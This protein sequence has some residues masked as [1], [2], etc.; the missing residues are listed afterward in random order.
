M[1]RLIESGVLWAVVLMAG[2]S[3]TP[4]PFQT[5]H[6]ILFAPD[7]MISVQQLAQRLG[8]D[9]GENTISMVT[10]RNAEN[11][12]MVFPD[13]GGQVSVNGKSVK[14]QGGFVQVRGV[15][16][17]PETLVGDLRPVLKP[18]T[19]PAKPP[20]DRAWRIVVDPGHGGEDSGT[21]SRSGLSEKS[22]TL[23]AAEELAQLLK[24][25]G[26]DVAMT[27]QTDAFIDVD[28]RA[29][30][31]NNFT[32]DLFISLHADSYANPSAGGFTVYTCREAPPES[33]A[34]AEAVAGALRK[35]GV[36]GMGVRQANYRILVCTQC[37]GILVELGWL[38]ND[39]DAAALAD[40]AV[41]SQLARAIADGIAVYFKQGSTP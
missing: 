26:F 22:V 39:H 8:L 21:V 33:R 6:D 27:R 4:A 1:R 7:K 13:A 3:Q 15:L 9:A 2:C 37:P 18:L 30:L 23:P 16:F 32:P 36:E 24:Q 34:A 25:D 35:A 5:G 31:A 19:A 17:V 20:A 12:V 38:S 14:T 28:D 10:L 29:A 41:L 11:H 40:P